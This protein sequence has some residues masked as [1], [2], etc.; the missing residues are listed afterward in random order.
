MNLIRE[1]LNHKIRSER[2]SMNRLKNSAGYRYGNTLVDVLKTP[3]KGVPSAMR[4]L[5]NRK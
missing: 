4:G 5:R 2:R 1:I 3:R